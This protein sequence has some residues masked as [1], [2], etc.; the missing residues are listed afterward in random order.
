MIMMM[1]IHGEKKPKIIRIMI[2]K[3]VSQNFPG[4]F[5]ETI[6]ILLNK[7]IQIIQQINQEKYILFK[8]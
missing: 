4:N 6:Q 8:K 2:R 5:L 1:G 7:M 3:G